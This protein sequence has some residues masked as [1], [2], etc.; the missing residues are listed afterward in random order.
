VLLGPSFVDSL[1]NNRRIGQDPLDFTFLGPKVLEDVV[2][3]VLDLVWAGCLS[4]IQDRGLRV[5]DDLDLLKGP[6]NLMAGRMSKEDHRFVEVPD[7]GGS[8]DRLVVFDEENGIQTRDIPMVDYHEFGPVHA[9]S[10]P[11]LPDSTPRGGTPD[12]ATPQGTVHGKVVDESLTS[13]ELGE[14]LDALHPTSCFGSEGNGLV[15]TVCIPG[16]GSAIHIGPSE[17]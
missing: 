14:T 10:E 12:R 13:G 6:A 7:L 4:E 2:G 16:H 5:D 8:Q 15:L 3:A 11:D 9:G 17:S 1:D